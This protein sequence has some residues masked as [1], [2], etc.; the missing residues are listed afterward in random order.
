MKSRSLSP[1]YYTKGALTDAS[2]LKVGMEVFQPNPDKPSELGHMGV[3]AGLV[4]F[5]GQMLHAVY[6][7][8]AI[9][10][11]RQKAIYSEETGP[12]LTEMNEKWDHWG[13][14]KYVKH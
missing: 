3:Y 8:R 10:N 7:S 14:S 1:C 6:Q 4:N 12:N 13:W 2:Q 9:Y 11:P 5:N